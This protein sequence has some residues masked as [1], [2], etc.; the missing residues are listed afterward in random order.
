VPLFPDG[1]KDDERRWYV[2]LSL[3]EI[4]GMGWLERGRAKRVRGDAER[5]FRSLART[6]VRE[7]YGKAHIRLAWEFNLDEDAWRIE[8]SPE[9]WDDFVGAWRNV[10]DWM[11]GEPGTEFKW[12]WNVLLGYNEEAAPE[13]GGFDPVRHAYPGD[14]YVDVVSCDL[15]DGHP[16]YF[17]RG[18]N[19][20]GASPELLTARQGM[21]WEYLAKGRKRSEDL[22]EEVLGEGVPSLDSY[23][24]FA[25]ARGKGFA[26]SEWGLVGGV[27]GGGDNPSFLERL[28]EWIAA[29]EVAYANYFEFM[30]LG[31][32]GRTVVVDHA[33]MPGFWEGDGEVGGASARRFLELWYGG[34]SE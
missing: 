14:E 32:D 15:Y 16:H 27:E 20:S 25:E 4:E 17:Y 28:H 13:A 6:L 24:R 7:G 30:G 19:G 34:N 10:H 12:V 21:M 18:M 3:E 33:L 29:N 11:S 5:A 9:H 8:M 26:I 22:P 23:R 2:G 31:E 1:L